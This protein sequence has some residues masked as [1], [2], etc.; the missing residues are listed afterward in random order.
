M[1]CSLPHCFFLFSFK[2]DFGHKQTICR[3]DNRRVKDLFRLL[4]CK[5]LSDS[6][7]VC[8]GWKCTL[9]TF[10]CCQQEVTGLLGFGKRFFRRVSENVADCFRR[11]GK[12]IIVEWLLRLEE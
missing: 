1:K 5:Y 3:V 7:L 9:A 8:R 10:A 2:F 6:L 4:R 11:A 12:G